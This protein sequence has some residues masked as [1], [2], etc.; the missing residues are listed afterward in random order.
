[1]SKCT[2]LSLIRHSKKAWQNQ[3][4]SFGHSSHVQR[5]GY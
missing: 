2:E 4:W 1:M 3:Q 5:D